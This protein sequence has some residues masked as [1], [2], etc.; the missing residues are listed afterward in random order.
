MEKRGITLV[1]YRESVSGF[2]E[3]LEGPSLG[4]VFK[5]PLPTDCKFDDLGHGTCAIGDCSSGGIDYGGTRAMSSAT[6]VEFTLDSGG[7]SQ[8]Y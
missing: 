6:L 2:L 7:A 4:L 3:F 8:D 5:R 1:T